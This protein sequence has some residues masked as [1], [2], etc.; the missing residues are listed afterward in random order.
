[1]Y[2]IVALGN[3]GEK[4]AS[5]RHNIGWVVMDSVS[6]LVN[7]PSPQLQS[8]LSGRVTDGKIAGLPVSVLYPDTYMNNSG[9]AVRKF[10]PRDELK[11]LIVLY[12][13]IALPF[14]E[15]KVTF[16][17]GAGGHNGLTSIIEKMGSKDFVRVR[18]GIGKVGFWPWSG[19]EVK[20]PKGGGALEK[21]VLGNLTKKESGEIEKVSVHALEVISTILKDGHTTAM[22]KFN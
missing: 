10:V 12:D 17:R 15:I 7:L 1:M 5:T 21:Y 8:A 18:I 20:R 6:A 19:S 4:Y 11:N 2:Y 13:D 14:G 22:N 9:A 3:P 16:G